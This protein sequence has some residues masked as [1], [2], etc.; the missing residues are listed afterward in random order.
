[1]G[2][3]S[4]LMV[5]VVKLVIAAAALSAIAL[6][7]PRNTYVEEELVQTSMYEDKVDTLK[8][9]FAQ[10]QSQI[11][12][13]SF[14][15]VTPRVQKVITKMIELVEKEI[16]PAIKEAHRADQVLLNDE[17]E[18]I[19]N[20][21]DAVQVEQNIL[22]GKADEIRQFIKEHNDLVV[23][24]FKRADAFVAA[25]DLWGVT[26]NNMTTTCC[27]KDNAAVVDVAYLEPSHSCDFK[28][29]EADKCISKVS[30]SVTSYVDPYFVEGRTHYLELVNNCNYLTQLEVS[31]H[32]A[33]DHADSECDKTETDTRA[34]AKVIEDES[35]KFQSLWRTLK[36][37]YNTNITIMQ[38]K[39]DVKQGEVEHDEKDR[40]NEWRATQ[41][42]KC[43]LTH[44]KEGGGFSDT[45]LAACQAGTKTD[46]YVSHLVINYPK[47]VKRLNW[48]LEPFVELSSYEKH[49]KT[50]WEIVVYTVPTCNIAA[51]KILPECTNH[52]K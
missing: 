21:A 35:E 12:D 20:Y 16:E 19:Q 17:R 36:N 6:A 27:A 45:E 39:Y 33:F 49:D 11:K 5:S 8:Q 15:E 41:T 18:K 26:H 10:L 1:M 28:A 25:R 48:D 34:K 23:E 44:Y 7:A 3:L 2:E 32:N 42:I 37:G 4:R 30:A 52:M 31:H 50:C 51:Q 24:W 29:P 38:N 14:A 43:M 22:R 9:Q 13:K 40:K 46:S 47:K